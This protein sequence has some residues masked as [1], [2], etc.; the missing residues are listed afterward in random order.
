[1]WQQLT[2]VCA[3]LIPQQGSW[4]RLVI[5]EKSF[6]KLLTT[7]KVFPSFV[8]IVR[9]FG[10]KTGYEDDSFGCFCNRTDYQNNVHGELALNADE[11]TIFRETEHSKRQRT[12]SS[13]WKNTGDQS[14]M[15]HGRSGK[16][17]FTIRLARPLGTLSLSSILLC[18][19]VND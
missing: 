4:G 3:S 19:F 5:D 6:R 2:D 7:F 8:D 18:L 17:E 16:W 14:L 15:I 1:M 10:E 9:S 13:M 12:W 11:M